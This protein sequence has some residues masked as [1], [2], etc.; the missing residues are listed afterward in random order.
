MCKMAVKVLDTAAELPFSLQ[1]LIG[2]RGKEEIVPIYAV[3]LGSTL[4]EEC[5]YPIQELKPIKLRLESSQEVT[6]V[7][8]WNKTYR[9]YSQEEEERSYVLN[10]QQPTVTI[11][12][13]GKTDYSYPWRFGVYHFEIVWGTQ[14]F[15]GGIRIE[16]KNV[17]WEQFKWMLSFMNSYVNAIFLDPKFRKNTP[18][19]LSAQ[20]NTQ[21]LYSIDQYVKHEKQLLHLVKRVKKEREW[22]IEKEY[23][24]SNVSKRRDGK[25]IKKEQKK[26]LRYY[27]RSITMKN[28]MV[29]FEQLA[30]ILHNLNDF[31]EQL[32]Q[33]QKKVEKHIQIIEGKIKKIN[34]Y[35]HSV[36]NNIAITD[37]DKTKY[38][39]LIQV[40]NIEL[41]RLYVEH[42]QIVQIITEV[43][44]FFR[45]LAFLLREEYS[46][47][48]NNGY[49]KNEKRLLKLVNEIL[50]PT[51]KKLEVEL[52]PTYLLYEYFV[53]FTSINVL[54][55]LG[56]EVD[57]L[58][59]SKQL[60]PSILNEDLMDGSMVVVKRNKEIFHIVYNELI[61]SN[62]DQI[63]WKQGKL[64]SGEESR[65]PD[66]RLDYYIEKNNV[67]I[68][69]WSILIEVK[70]S[71]L[72]NIYQQLGNT[73]AMEQMYKYWSIKYVCEEN[74]RKKYMRNP[75]KEVICIYPGGHSYRMIED[76][77]GVFLQMYPAKNEKDEQVII[78]ANELKTIITRL[79][80]EYS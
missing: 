80:D 52:K 31:Q 60:E 1:L 40:Y 75:I 71:P 35:H 12:E 69:Q 10:L 11:Y 51:K 67:K 19:L 28:G 21:V 49:S 72:Y 74:S 76:G 14:R 20:K 43:S 62:Y 57:G 26:P 9:V 7:F 48:R 39:Q 45:Q 25:S 46:S 4:L 65:K 38:R 63:Q 36:K 53:Y 16:P 42:K 66:V 70:Y 3:C 6:I 55:E 13:H 17:D 61:D 73:K 50:Y 30:Q 8:H 23:E 37:R 64:F 68:F 32:N 54:M 33:L 18:I 59:V 27:N 24:W 29:A 41:E 34:A 56:F 78:G 2:S 58:S 77:C 47:E 22:Q 15:Y 5:I 44:R 79:I